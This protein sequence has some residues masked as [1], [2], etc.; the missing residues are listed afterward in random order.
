MKNVKE[1]AK[2]LNVHFR[3][4]HLWIK[5]GKIKA[6]QVGRK[7]LIEQTEIEHIKSSGLRK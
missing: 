6:T 3:T 5:Q 4:I 7:Y 1:V 2:I